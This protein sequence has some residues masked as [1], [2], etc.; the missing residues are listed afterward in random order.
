M[1][2]GQAGQSIGA[3]LIDATTGA[4]FTGTV[5]AYV[6]GDAGTQAIGTVGSGLCTHE[7]N[8][9]H[10]YLPSAAETNYSLIAFTFTGTGAI[11]ATIQVAT[12]TA[13]QAA[14][15]AATSVVSSIDADLYRRLNYS[16]TPAAEVVL[17]LR[18]FVNQTHRQILTKP[19]LGR[20]RDDT[21]TFLSVAN[22]TTYA[23]PPAIAKIQHVQDRTNNRPIVEQSL[24]WLRQ[25]DAG[26][27]S[28]GGPSHVYIPRGYQAV[29]VQPSAAAEI[30]IKSTSASDTNTAWLEGFRTGGY[31]ISLGPITMTGGTAVSF[32][33]AYTDIIEIT[34]VYLSTA[35]VGTVTVH[36]VSGAGTEL[37]RIPIGATASRY[38]AIQL[39]PTPGS[40]ITYHVDYTRVI[41]NLVNG[42]D[43]PLLPEDFHWLLVEG[44]LI[45]EW[46]KK[47]DAGRREAAKRDF[48]EGV[49]ALTSWVLSNP[50]TVASLRPVARG[51]ST[52]GP[53]YPADVWR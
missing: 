19:G 39:W 13:G 10:T 15:V 21:I 11:P 25:V 40:V 46:S 9:Y 30:F 6:T 18:T 2:K 24:G 47:D 1:I 42:T 33:T 3:E 50:D 41:P 45:K 37:A 5:T 49:A 14:A 29:A 20:L 12:I 7:G 52:L 26:L 48:D 22:Q 34:K 36:S 27:T 51:Y 31:P 38:L 17:R 4:A 23:L 8:G 28:T 35:A 44:A 53:T 32:G 43:E 16:T